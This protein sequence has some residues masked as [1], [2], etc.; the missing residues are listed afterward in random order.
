[1]TEA[2]N[3]R[4]RVAV[5]TLGCKSNQYD[6]SAIEDALRAGEF[7]I[8]P[9]PAE[10]DAYIINTCTVTAKTD[11]QSRALIRRVRRLNPSAIVIVTG[12]YAQVSPD[13]VKRI[14]DVDYILGN[15]QKG[16]VLE[17]LKKGRRTDGPETIVGPDK[18]G[19]PLTLRA[20]ASSG[21][22]R[23]NIKVQ[24]GC[25]KSCSYC[26]IP[27]ARGS[28]KSL[29]LDDVERE[30][31]TLI[32]A[33]Y[34]E[35]V[36]TGI[37]LGAYGADLSAKAD[38]SAVLELIEERDWPC[39]F[40]ISS[41]D[42]DEVTE[43]VIEVIK[44]AKRICNHLH[45]C[46]QSGDNAIIKKMKRPYTRELFAERVGKLAASVPDISIG[47]DVIAGFPGEGSGEFEN[48]FSLLKDLPVTYLH[49]F[50]FSRRSGTPAV[51][52][53]G[54]V[55]SR[56]IK[57]RCVRLKE[58]DA[59]KRAEFYKGF[60]GRSASVLAESAVDNET[61]VFKGKTTNYIPVEFKGEEGLRNKIMDLRL[62][63]V[64]SGHMTGTFEGLP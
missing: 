55:E 58:L 34:K 56:I 35:I 2:P 27:K 59:V 51:S 37:H 32:G 1:M 54:Q 6:S 52:Y 46:L 13:E 43:E 28:S 31:D 10:A 25:N 30:V 12:C 22:T 48:T 18:D 41:L 44:G 61:N 42:P 40:R 49:I 33:G 62:T 5:A 15:P 29:P 26:I 57:K 7:A 64:K 50:P 17:C 9:F 38:I 21:R 14:E 23:V 39:R 36:L 16:N 24:D 20:A 11:A 8:V 3:N 47:A 53:A 45:L 60:I 4:Q 19:T 63:G